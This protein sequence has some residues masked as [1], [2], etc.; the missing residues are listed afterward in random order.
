MEEVSFISHLLFL[1]GYQF[2]LELFFAMLVLSANLKKRRYFIY[3]LIL[4]LAVG[5]PFYFM[6][7]IPVL[8]LDLAYIIIFVAMFL[9]SVLLYEEKLRYIVI[10]AVAAFA[11]QHLTWN[12][13]YIILDIF[14]LGFEVPR[15]LSLLTYFVCFIGLY[16]LFLYFVKHYKL[17][18]T[19]VNDHFFVYIV[20]A[21]IIV[22][23]FVL[24]Q[25]IGSWSIVTRI[26][27]IISSLACLV[28]IFALPYA[29]DHKNAVI[30][31]QSLE[32][33]LEIQAK[34]KEEYA[35]DREVIRKYYHD[36]KHQLDVF[37]T[38][39]SREE[40]LNRIK[41]IKKNILIYDSYAKTGNYIV[42]IILTQKS[43]VCTKK[44]IRFSYIVDG[45]AL[46]MFS[47][48]DI[49]ILLGNILDNAIE[50][51]EKEEDEYRL[52]KLN[53]QTRNGLLVINQFN[54]TKNQPVFDDGLI[55]TSKKNALM[56]GYG[57]KS[58]SY[59]CD[60]YNGEMDVK[61][62]DGAFNLELIFPLNK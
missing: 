1:G 8:N 61:L 24:S 31:R 39:E 32:K 60:K 53:I 40:I 54:Y 22:I 23:T 3:L 25:M 49:T 9:F 17:R 33:L 4:V 48:N 15:W 37:E 13:M 59:I 30:E 7:R 11:M 38:L 46:K 26:Y 29:V 12:I 50:G 28:L 19:N 57:L 27:T 5:I 52:I 36:M 16:A 56:H 44:N 47:N 55:K 21:V 58:I 45:E 41:D 10:N 20:G 18:L 14:A 34:E 62:E 42:D 6:P 43:L 2:Y 35:S 51:I